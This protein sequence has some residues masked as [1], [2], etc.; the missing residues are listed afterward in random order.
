MVII[1]PL[2]SIRQGHI[3]PLIGGLEGGSSIFSVIYRTGGIGVLALLL[4]NTNNLEKGQ[5]ERDDRINYVGWGMDPD[6]NGNTDS[7]II[8]H[9]M[10]LVEDLREEIKG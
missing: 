10:Y 4:L 5:G 8:V 2:F 7:I 3:T 1:V 9:L 6:S